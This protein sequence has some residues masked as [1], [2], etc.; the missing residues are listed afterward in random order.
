MMI[1]QKVAEFVSDSEAL[2][3]RWLVAIHADG[4][5]AIEFDE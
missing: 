1:E 3:N 4:S 2:S 5:A